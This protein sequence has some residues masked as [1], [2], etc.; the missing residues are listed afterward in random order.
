MQNRNSKGIVPKDVPSVNPLWWGSVRRRMSNIY[1]GLSK[2]EKS[3]V[4]PSRV[5]FGTMESLTRLMRRMKRVLSLQG[6][7]TAPSIGPEPARDHTVI[8]RCLYHSFEEPTLTRPTITHELVDDKDELYSLAG[9]RDSKSDGAPVV[10]VPIEKS[11]HEIPLRWALGD[12]AAADCSC[13]TAPPVKDRS[14]SLS[15]TTSHTGEEFYLL[16]IIRFLKCQYLVIVQYLCIT[17][18]EK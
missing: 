14:Y 8:A 11:Q 13:H 2:K 1:F 17:S 9:V 16:Y 4:I 6:E 7:V 5:P 15:R 3:L 12:V 10:R 18:N